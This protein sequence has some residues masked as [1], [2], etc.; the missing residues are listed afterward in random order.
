MEDRS[1]EQPLEPAPRGAEQRID[2]VA[3]FQFVQIRTAAVRAARRERE[4]PQSAAPAHAAPSPTILAYE[5]RGEKDAFEPGTLA[6]HHGVAAA[7]GALHR[8]HHAIVRPRRA[9]ASTYGTGTTR[10]LSVVTA[11]RPRDEPG[12]SRSSDSPGVGKSISNFAV[13]GVAEAGIFSWARRAGRHGVAPSRGSGVSG[14]LI[15]PIG[16][17]SAGQLWMESRSGAAGAACVSDRRGD[18]T[19]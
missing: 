12:S 2:P 7:M 6:A 5:G 15:S 14:L 11:S 19:E 3:G 8:V 4:R 1:A 18:P 13:G 10:I 9:A 16:V 17:L